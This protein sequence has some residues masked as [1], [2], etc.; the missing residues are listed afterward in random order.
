MHSV[1]NV[2]LP[3]TQ[4][5]TARSGKSESINFKQFQSKLG[6]A[7]DPFG[8]KRLSATRA[9]VYQSHQTSG[10]P[11]NL[12]SVQVDDYLMAST[13]GSISIK[14]NARKQ[15]AIRESNA[16]TQD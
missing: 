1:T 15:S 14:A 9:V 4:N 3:M 2:N 10:A 11:N 12:S 16:S 8:K 6:G 13:P 5:F 7:D